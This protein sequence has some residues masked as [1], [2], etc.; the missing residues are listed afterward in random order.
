MR[1]NALAEKGINAVAGS[2]EKLIWDYKIERLV[3]FLQR[4][5]SR[6]RNDSLDAQLLKAINIR[7][8]IQFAGQQFVTAR[9]PRQKRYFATGKSSQYVRIRRIAKRSLLA[10]LMRVAKA[11]HVIQATAAYDA[12]LCLLQLRS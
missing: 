1:H 3:F 10:Y 11:R 12:Y 5:N 4:A 9:V 8:E 6:N 2:I 7:P